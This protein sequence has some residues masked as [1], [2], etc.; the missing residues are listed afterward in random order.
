MT[1]REEVFAAI[2][3]EREYQTGKWGGESYDRWQSIG[4]WLAYMRHYLNMAEAAHTTSDD[5]NA[6]LIQIRKVAA[7]AVACM[8]V[9]GAPKR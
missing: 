1:P 9:H 6:P 5:R 7:L 4:D 2:N 3:G 8:E